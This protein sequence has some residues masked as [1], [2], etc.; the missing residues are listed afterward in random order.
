MYYQIENILSWK[1]S[2]LQF[3][4][5]DDHSWFREEKYFIMYIIGEI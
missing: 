4:I 5:E 3:S 2:Y 1:F